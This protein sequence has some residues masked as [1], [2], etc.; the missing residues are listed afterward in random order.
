M[1]NVSNKRV[2]YDRIQNAHT[3]ITN[4][5]NRNSP[6]HELLMAIVNYTIHPNLLF[7]IDQIFGL[8]DIN[9]VIGSKK[10]KNMKNRIEFVKQRYAN[11]DED[12]VKIG[13]IIYDRLFNAFN[14]LFDYGIDRA[15]ILCFFTSIY[16]LFTSEL[17][18]IQDF[19]IDLC[20]ERIHEEALRMM[21]DNK[22]KITINS[23]I[24]FCKNYL[25]VNYI[26]KYIN[27]YK[28]LVRKSIR[29]IVTDD[30]DY[31]KIHNLVLKYKLNVNLIEKDLFNI[32]SIDRNNAKFFST[33]QIYK[34]YIEKLILSTDKNSLLELR[35]LLKTKFDIKSIQSVVEKSIASDVTIDEI[36]DAINVIDD[37]HKQ[38][39][40][41]NCD[42]HSKREI[43]NI[44]K[45]M[46]IKTIRV[47]RNIPLDKA[48]KEQLNY[49]MLLKPPITNLL[50][51]YDDCSGPDMISLEE[52][53]DL[54][55][56]FSDNIILNYKN[57]K[58]CFLRNNLVEFLDRKEDFYNED[59][60]TI[61][62]YHANWKFAWQP[63]TIN[64]LMNYAGYGGYPNMSI[65]YY[66]LPYPPFMINEEGY[67][68]IKY[69][70]YREF[71]IQ[72]KYDIDS[73]GK[74]IPYMSRI[75]NELGIF[76]VSMDH[77]QT[78]GYPIYTLEPIY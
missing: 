55:V 12:E 56:D 31:V 25:G 54:N 45:K 59:T 58:H 43:L 44:A 6:E 67:K 20:K 48:T 18:K 61:I 30:I 41:Q 1:G 15:I 78:P 60:D 72:E 70:S 29:D 53:K 64:T 9:D 34:Q 63:K 52:W 5:I 2:K 49:H 42:H 14:N 36:C 66:K 38:K 69:S 22:F 46:G 19:H 4:K 17:M 76:G 10:K 21:N 71:N 65:K 23:Y 73:K 13:V 74:Q 35:E 40:I 28:K 32:R 26:N 50:H 8:K 33:H 11:I 16:P 47:Y 27:S 77:G 57:K 39:V 51:W 3:S 68:Y 75:G 7:E 37:T 62:K 24:H